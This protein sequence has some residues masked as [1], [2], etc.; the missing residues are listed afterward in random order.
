MRK[1]QRRMLAAML[2][3]SDDNMIVTEG[4]PEIAEKAGYSNTGGALSDALLFL[5]QS[6]HILKQDDGTWL[7]TL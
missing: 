3:L 5:E 2:L 6:N 4:I 7:I 1:T